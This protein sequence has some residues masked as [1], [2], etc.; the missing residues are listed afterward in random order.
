MTDLDLV[1][2][3]ALLGVAL[4]YCELRVRPLLAQLVA[5]RA[6]LR[7]VGV[8]SGVTPDEL[9]DHARDPH[10]HELAAGLLK[11]SGGAS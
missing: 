5:G 2:S 4:A 1:A 7:A 9:R 8:K 11:T 10:G 6:W 3:P